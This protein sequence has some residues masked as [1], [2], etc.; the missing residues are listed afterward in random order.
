MFV[1]FFVAASRADYFEPFNSAGCA[2]N[3]K[4]RV[5]VVEV[6]FGEQNQ[7]VRRLFKQML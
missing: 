3:P 7:G 5:A 6:A 1:A 4:V 2:R